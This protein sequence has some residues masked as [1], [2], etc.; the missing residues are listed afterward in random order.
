MKRMVSR[1]FA[2]AALL[3]PCASVVAAPN[4]WLDRTRIAQGDTVTLNIESE[5]QEAPDFPALDQDFIARGQS[6]RTETTID[7]GSVRTRTLWAI[8]LEPKR[9]GELTIPAIRVGAQSTAALSLTVTPGQVGVQAQGQDVFLEVQVDQDAPY[10]GQPVLYTLRL[11]YAITLLD[12]DLDPPAADGIDV[13]R[14]GDD[15]SYQRTVAGRRYQTLERNFVLIPERSGSLQLGAARFR[16]RTLAGLRDPV[17]GGARAVSALG[18]DI[19]LQVKPQPAQAQQPWLPA[20]AATLTLQVPHEDARVG[21]PVNVELS[22]QLQGAAASQV[23]ELQLPEVP[24]ARVFPDVPQVREKWVDG[25]MHVDITRR[26]AVVP[27]Q[28]GELAMPTVRVPWWNTLTDSA[29]VAQ[30]GHAA[31]HVVAASAD[32]PAGGE[33][34][35]DVAAA[36]DATSAATATP[37]VSAPLPVVALGFGVRVWQWLSLL[38][39]LAW[40]GTWWW[41]WRRSRAPQDR[42]A[43]LRKSAQRRDPLDTLRSAAQHGDLG[44]ADAALRA[45]SCDP[46]FD[47]TTL[48]AAQREAVAALRAALWGTGDRQQAGLLLRRAFAAGLS[49]RA[50]SLAVA[51]PSV[52]PPLYPE[53]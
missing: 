11:S 53:R 27:G 38:L 43:Q 49:V 25:V 6:S 3:L 37:A 4:A 28:V 35:P 32:A 47:E 19:T 48:D 51:E 40:M 16:G 30:T 34:A 46:G 8:A 39:L 14:S 26:F 33:H 2:L 5:T 7:N 31:L 44:A 10:V 21:E 45:L 36:G 41:G 24:G 29:Q 17:F 42:V 15:V 1:W 12:G 23:P 22:L 9:S 52:L 13:R 18:E 20:Q 50:A